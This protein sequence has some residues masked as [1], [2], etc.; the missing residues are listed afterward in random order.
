M[1]YIHSREAILAA[2]LEVAQEVGLAEVTYRL[3]GKRCGIPDRTVVYYF[4]TKN[5]LLIA[6]LEAVERKVREPMLELV[7]DRDLT[8]GQAVSGMWTALA[9]AEVD[10]LFRIYIELFGLAAARRPPYDEL[11]ARVNRYWVDWLEQRMAGPVDQRRT[12]AAAVFAQVDGLL[13]FRH[14]NSPELADR[15]ARF[16]QESRGERSAD[17]RPRP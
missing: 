17:P 12:A 7:G 2:A 13:L 1:G 14:L 16:L 3:V 5:D 8:V 11:I 9:T 4:P 10:P 15:A 6:V